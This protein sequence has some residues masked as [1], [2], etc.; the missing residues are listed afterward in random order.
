MGHEAVNGPELHG[1]AWELVELHREDLGSASLPGLFLKLGTG[2]FD[3][4]IKEIL[5]S[6]ARD[7]RVLHSQLATRTSAWVSRFA[8][9]EDRDALVLLVNRCAQPQVSAGRNASP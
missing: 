5:S 3:V 4:A 1:L 9:H 7:G 6:L 8:G 2:Q